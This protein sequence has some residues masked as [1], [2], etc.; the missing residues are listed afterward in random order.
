M[1]NSETQGWLEFSLACNYIDT[2]IPTKNYISLSDEIRQN[3]LHYMIENP[4]SLVLVIL[5]KLDLFHY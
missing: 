4:A 3:Y 5:N 2:R 1:E